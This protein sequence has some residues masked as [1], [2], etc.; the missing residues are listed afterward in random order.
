MS[1]LSLH[2]AP[3]QKLQQDRASSMEREHAPKPSNLAQ[4]LL[5]LQRTAGNQAVTHVLQRAQHHSSPGAPMSE[6]PMLPENGPYRS[7]A[8]Q[9]RHHLLSSLLPSTTI[10]RS[11]KTW[12]GEFDTDWYELETDEEKE[13]EVGVDIDLKFEPNEYVDAELIG[14]VQTVRSLGQWGPIPAS[15][16]WKEKAEQEA[17]E[18]TQIP[19]DEP[20][21]GT[22]IDQ[23]P[24][25]G[26]PLYATE[27]PH[28]GD[29]L[30]DTPTNCNYGHHG[31]HYRDKTGKLHHEKALLID[32]P[33][34]SSKL[35][36]SGQFFE[37]TAL[38]VKGVQEG[39]FYGSVEWGWK[40]DVGG[41][42]EKLPLKL[43][44]NDV[45][46]TVF[47]RATARWDIAK[48]SEGKETIFLPVVTGKYTNTE[49][50]LLFSDLSHY[51][52]TIIGKLEKNTRLE[53]ID[54]GSAKPFNKT[55]GKYKWWKVTVMDGTHK[56]KVGWVMQANLSD[57]MTR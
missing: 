6:V 36:K 38:A 48:T 41:N 5:A 11:V 9:I 35:K 32:K 19:G 56:G 12:G 53:V 23:Y 18:S 54:K 22:K 37:T 10:Q 44:S 13:E 40:K 21:A 24:T 55:A 7:S 42:V 30:A 33:R 49:G 20:K 39:T 27:K 26:N 8:L 47:A 28:P 31:W 52:T 50:V 2:K 15:L 29:T 25:Q 3:E 4:D 17:F 43:V 45:P 14:M 51:P 57:K 1:R 34:M 46:S 16:F